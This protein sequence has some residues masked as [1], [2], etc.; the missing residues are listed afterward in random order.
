MIATRGELERWSNNYSFEKEKT[1][2]VNV[3]GCNQGGRII[4]IHSLSKVQAKCLQ[5]G[6]AVSNVVIAKVNQ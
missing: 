5:Q 3:V 2:D 6:N 4:S 1:Y